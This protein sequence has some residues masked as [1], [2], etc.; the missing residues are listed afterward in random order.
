MNSDRTEPLFSV[1]VPVLNG[2]GTLRQSLASL[3]ASSLTD[4]ELIVVDDGST[5]G[6]AEIATEFGARILHTGGRKGPGAARNLGVA[7]AL[8]EFVFFIDADCSPDPDALQLAA[9][10][11]HDDAD[12]EALFGSY[13]DQPTAQ[14]LVSQYRNLQHHHVHQTSA[15]EASTFWA[16]C[17][18]MRRSTFQDLG[19]FDIQRYPRPS[20]EDIELGYRL[21][22]K[23]GRIRLVPEVQVKHHKAW[24]LKSVLR[25]DLLD[26]GIPWTR[27]LAEESGL[28]NDLNVSFNSRLSVVMALATLAGLA[29]APWRSQAL[30]VTLGAGLL[31]LWL[32]RDFYRLLARKGGLKLLVAGAGLHWIYQLNCAV[33]YSLGRFSPW[34]KDPGST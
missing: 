7:E 20:I 8:G 11:L 25:T 31:L 33:A 16:G 2:A 3:R 30:W 14:G 21:R 6:S 4:F 12:I 32:N 24:T 19:G 22:A 34:P 27:L 17:G 1:I 18:V 10:V 13:D 26:R 15:R 29:L 28:P 9:D 23:G 5:D